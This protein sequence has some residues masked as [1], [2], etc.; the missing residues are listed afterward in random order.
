MTAAVARSA[1]PRVGLK[2]NL[3]SL[4]AYKLHEKDYP[5]FLPDITATL[6]LSSPLNKET[7]E[8]LAKRTNSKLENQSD[9]AQTQRVARTAS[10]NMEA[11]GRMLEALRPPPAPAPPAATLQTSARQTEAAEMARLQAAQ[12]QLAEDQRRAAR[13]PQLANQVSQHRTQEARG[14]LP[15]ITDW[16]APTV[17][18]P[19]PN[20]TVE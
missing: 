6:A 14:T 12:Q 4:S 19:R 2:R 11:L 20:P 3:D 15:R 9:A 16:W 18:S 13:E 10:V 8:G 17:A 1:D 5:L 7:E